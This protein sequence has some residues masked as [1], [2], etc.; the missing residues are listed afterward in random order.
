MDVSDGLAWDLFRLGRAS[1]VAI[2]LQHVPIHPDARRAAR[3][4]GRTA[5]DHALHDGEDHELLAAVPR[6]KLGGLRAAAKRAG[7]PLVCIGVARRGAGLTLV[8]DGERQAWHPDQ[9]GWKHGT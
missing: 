5:L 9:G 1:R 8:M 6:S 7:V 3:R 2:E 4:S